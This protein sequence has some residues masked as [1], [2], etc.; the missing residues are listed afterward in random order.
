M[1]IWGY[2]HII[3]TNWYL[4]STVVNST[5]TNFILQIISQ[6][7]LQAESTWGLRLIKKRLAYRGMEN[8]APR[9][10]CNPLGYCSSPIRTSLFINTTVA[11]GHP[12]LHG[13]QVGMQVTGLPQLPNKDI[14]FFYKYMHFSG[15]PRKTGPLFS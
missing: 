15:A 5:L 14:I 11:V 12:R 3:F 13:P 4:M 6:H 1:G 10:V 7:S 2:L 9:Q 8:T